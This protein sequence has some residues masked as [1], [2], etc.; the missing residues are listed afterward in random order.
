[1]LLVALAAASDVAVV[2]VSNLAERL[3]MPYFPITGTA[4]F[5]LA[6]TL[7]IGIYYHRDIESVQRGQ[8]KWVWMRGF[9]GSVSLSVTILAVKVGTPMGEVMALQSVNMVMAAL[10]GRAFLGEAL[11]L[12][13]GFALICSVSGAVLVSKPEV[14]LGLKSSPGGVPW[15]GYGLALLGGVAQ[16]GLFIAARKSQGLSG[17]LLSCSLAAQQSV[18]LWTVSLLGVVSDAPLSAI[19]VGPFVALIFFVLLVVIL[20]A[21]IAT[22]SVGAQMCPAAAGSTIFTSVMMSLGFVGQTVLQGQRPEA[23]T[24]CG[25]ALLLLAVVILSAARYHYRSPHSCSVEPFDIAA[26]DVPSSDLTNG[27]EASD[28]DS[29]ASFV[30]SEFSGISPSEREL[31][32]ARRRAAAVTSVLPQSIGMASA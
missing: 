17:R 5:T 30:A 29:L 21:S 12:I 24:V 6:V 1:M 18:C 3:N 20:F 9:F 22:F 31:G 8:W 32:A 16:G 14:M 27:D 13:H 25:A 7:G 28:V 26:S 19:E 2:V 23:L 10:W 4:L 11:H 15:L